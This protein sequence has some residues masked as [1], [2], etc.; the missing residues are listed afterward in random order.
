MQQD[1]RAARQE[2]TRSSSPAAEAQ[3]PPVVRLL[4]NPRRIR[5]V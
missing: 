3:A 4:A 1:A 5:R 2:D